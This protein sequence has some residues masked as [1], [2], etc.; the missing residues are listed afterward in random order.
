MFFCEQIVGQ[1][2]ILMCSTYC[3]LVITFLMTGLYIHIPFCKQACSYCNFHFSTNVQRKD[4]VIHALQ[5]ELEIRCSGRVPMP[6]TS[7]YL[8]GGTP[9]LLDAADLEGLFAA[10]AKHFEIPTDIEITIEANP[11]DLVPKKL[12]MIANSPI[13]RL[14][15]GIQ[16]FD[17]RDLDYMNRAHDAQQAHTAILNAQSFGFSN[18]S[19]D[20]IYGVPGMSL[21]RW[22]ENL[23]M[24]LEYQVPHLSCYALTIED[25]TALAHRVSKGLSPAPSHAEAEAQFRMLMDVTQAHGYEHYEISNF[26]RDGYIAKHNTSYWQS[27][28]YIGIGP[29]A[30]SFDGKRRS[31]N[32]ANNMKYV[33]SIESGQL[34]QTVEVL[35]D[36]D[37][38]NEYVMTRLR[39]KW[40]CHLDHITGMG[41]EYVKLFTKEIE[42][43]L[44][45]GL[46]FCED[47]RYALSLEG[48]LFADRIA[49]DL[50]WV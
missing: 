14:S 9:S 11:D 23:R 46:V 44:R 2:R 5:G 37:R 33:K 34:P 8:G 7:I 36:A 6:L 38:Y 41:E 39:T 21:D 22:R 10:I 13:N 29:S 24:S 15:I 45:E 1:D 25:R 35:T 18:V 19:M 49:A 17:Q 28:S 48:K 27:L 3:P 30:H 16:S 20:L 32:V 47:G 42:H 4:A 40:G 43:Y 12:E 50:F 26:A 31:W